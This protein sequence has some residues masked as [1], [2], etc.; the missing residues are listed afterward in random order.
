[1]T[2]PASRTHLAGKGVDLFQPGHV[3]AADGGHD[4]GRQASLGQQAGKRLPK[5]TLSDT[6][7]KTWQ[8]AHPKSRILDGR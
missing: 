7:W 3:Q 4:R 1:L 8:R 5:R 2:A 6:S